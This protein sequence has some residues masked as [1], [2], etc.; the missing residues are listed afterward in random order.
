MLTGSVSALSSAAFFGAGLDFAAVEAAGFA[1]ARG[2]GLLGIAWLLG[3][4]ALS[5]PAWFGAGDSAEGWAGAWTGADAWAESWAGAAV[6]GWAG[7]WAWAKGASPSD[8]PLA[9]WR[10]D[11]SWPFGRGSVLEFMIRK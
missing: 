6:G 1:A 4:V 5:A 8:C 7:G 2:L 11:R 9:P 3:A 10:A